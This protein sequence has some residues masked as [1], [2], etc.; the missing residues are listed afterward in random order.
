MFDI[1]I[2]DI[3]LPG[4][5]L[6]SSH[7]VCRII[8]FNCSTNSAE[9]DGFS[10]NDWSLAIAARSSLVHNIPGTPLNIEEINQYIKR[11]ILSRSHDLLTYHGSRLIEVTPRSTCKSD[12]GALISLDPRKTTVSSGIKTLA[13]SGWVQKGSAYNHAIGCSCNSSSSSSSFS[14]AS[15]VDIKREWIPKFGALQNWNPFESSW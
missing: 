8:S 4:V 13:L 7:A 3:N 10:F 1:N 5:L 15:T 14:A 2:L 6:H 9:C 12:A 11:N